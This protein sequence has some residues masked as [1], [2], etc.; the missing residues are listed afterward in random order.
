MGWAP[1]VVV[2]YLVRFRGMTP[3]EWLAHVRAR[4]PVVCPN[5]HAVPRV[6]ERGI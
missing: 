3:D 5:M 2:T 6:L 4:R 1:A